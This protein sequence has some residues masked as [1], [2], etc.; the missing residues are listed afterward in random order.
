MRLLPIND[1]PRNI[2]GWKADRPDHRD[3]AFMSSVRPAHLPDHTDL[4]SYCSPVEDQS[5]IGSCTANAGTSAMEF[6]AIRLGKPRLNF[7]RLFLYYTERVK[8]EGTDPAEDSGA[9]IRD[10]MKALAVYGTCAETTWPYD[11]T[12]MATEPSSAAWTEAK[13]HQI[14]KYYRCSGLDGIRAC[15]SEGFSVVAGF[16]VPSRIDSPDTA[17]TGVIPY[18]LPNERIIGGHCVHLVGYNDKKKQILFQNSWGTTWGQQ[19]FGFLPYKY[20]TTGLA[21]DFWTIR[22][23]EF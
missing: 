10:T 11:I 19:G 23:E 18:P 8:I 22:F 2:R 7:S 13:N 21:S 14:L 20:F 5:D 9:Q 17:A 4:R 12:K 6:L 16:S 1:K 15:L 3:M